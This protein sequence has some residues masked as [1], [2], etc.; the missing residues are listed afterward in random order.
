MAVASRTTCSARDMLASDVTIRYILNANRSCPVPGDINTIPGYGARQ[1]LIQ[2]TPGA[3]ILG[4]ALALAAGDRLRLPPS[5][6][7]PC[8]RLAHGRCIEPRL[9]NQSASVAARSCPA[10]RQ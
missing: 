5:R 9:R 10:D 3:V 2:R 4:G 6:T 7:F 8:D 1:P